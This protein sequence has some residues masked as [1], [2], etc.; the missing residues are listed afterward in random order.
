M[1]PASAPA[2]ITR[3]LRG[4]AYPSAPQALLPPPLRDET[5]G[6]FRSG[7]TAEGDRRA[8]GDSP[9]RIESRHLRRHAAAGRV[10]QRRFTETSSGEPV[11]LVELELAGAGAI[12]LEDERGRRQRVVVLC[13]LSHFHGATT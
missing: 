3:F 5:H 10:A 7:A 2:A 6:G 9:A 8:G 4:V 12:H 1:R 13:Y 11:A